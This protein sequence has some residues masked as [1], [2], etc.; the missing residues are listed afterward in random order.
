[1]LSF[2]I[3]GSLSSTALAK[4]SNLND[5]GSSLQMLEATATV[6]FALEAENVQLGDVKLS[7]VT[8][9][10]DGVHTVLFSQDSS[11][12]VRLLLDPER[13]NSASVRVLSPSGR[14]MAIG[15]R[16]S[17][18]DFGENYQ[19]G[20]TRPQVYDLSFDAPETGY[21]R[22]EVDLDQGTEDWGVAYYTSIVGVETEG[23]VVSLGETV[24]NLLLVTAFAESEGLNVQGAAWTVLEPELRTRLDFPLEP[25]LGDCTAFSTVSDS[26]AKKMDLDVEEP[27]GAAIAAGSKRGKDVV[28]ATSFTPYLAGDWGFGLTATKMQ[29]GYN[30]T[31][32]AVMVACMP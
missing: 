2:L 31:H 26:R 5:L 24:L 8:E 29:R 20:E 11:P 14:V 30:D 27:G 19:N 18:V 4:T 3:L 1:V 25:R 13:A 6:M 16:T 15:E 21:Y 7:T 23:G 10:R 28:A 32:A 17:E 22:I 9:D 12:R